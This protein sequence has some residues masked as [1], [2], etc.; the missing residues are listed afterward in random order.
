MLPVT[1][2]QVPLHLRLGRAYRM[3]GTSY[4]EAAPCGDHRDDRQYERLTRLRGSAGRKPHHQTLPCP[5]EADI[6]TRAAT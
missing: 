5:A 6:D 2:V 1:I 4:R 3:C